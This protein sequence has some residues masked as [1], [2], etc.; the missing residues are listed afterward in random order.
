MK[1]IFLIAAEHHFFQVE[2]AKKYFSLTKKNTIL[3]VM[4]VGA[5]SK[6]IDRV[7]EESSFLEVHTFDTWIFKDLFFRRKP[8]QQFIKYCKVLSQTKQDYTF[9]YSQYESD[10]DLLFLSIVQPK[11]LY[12]M[13]E[14]S[15]SFTVAL[16]RSK[17]RLPIKNALKLAL[18]S[19][20]YFNNIS[21]PKMITYFTKYDLPKKTSD[22]LEKY[23]VFK[24]NNPFIKSIKNEAAFLGTSISDIGMMEEKIYLSFLKT[25]FDNNANKEI[26][27][28]FP[29]RKESVEKLHKIIE[30]GFV[31]KEIGIP[32]ETFFEKQTACPELIC[33][34]FTTG[35]LDNISKSN[36]HFPILKVYKFDTSLL[37][38]D[39]EVYND[40]YLEMCKNK[41]LFFEK[42]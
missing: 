31:I 29:H 35:V 3:L 1:Y 17:K 4:N 23:D 41:D 22:R 7:R 11:V 26:F 21:Y 5:I 13:D 6:F 24:Q 8:L 30:I 20:L 28:Y 36:A 16:N 37:A 27:Y 42:I 12:L 33:S 34:F 18:K 14:G 9:F 32:F 15:A 40:I 25:I 10:P 19:I 2:A 38:F 39:E